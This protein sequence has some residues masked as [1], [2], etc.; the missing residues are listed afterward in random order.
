MYVGDRL[1]SDRRPYFRDP[2]PYLEHRYH[3]AKKNYISIA[4]GEIPLCDFKDVFACGLNTCVCKQAK[5]D[6]L[7]YLFFHKI[8]QV[9]HNIPKGE[10]GK[11]DK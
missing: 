3:L 2:L 6:F 9:G 11:T 5:R 4:N 8:S 7:E 1:I 10:E